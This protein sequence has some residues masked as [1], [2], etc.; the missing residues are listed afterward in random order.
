MNATEIS[1]L[2]FFLIFIMLP[3]RNSFEDKVG[4]LFCIPFQTA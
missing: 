1:K 3:L 2:L 4:Y